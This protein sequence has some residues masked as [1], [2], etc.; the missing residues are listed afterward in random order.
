MGEIAEMMLEGDLCE[1][2][3]CYMGGSGDGFPRRCASCRKEQRAE[4]HQATLARH[5]QVKKVPCPTCGRKVKACGLSD[6]QRD[7]HKAPK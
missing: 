4:N 5:Q 2:C 7:A 3:G 1:G 6:H